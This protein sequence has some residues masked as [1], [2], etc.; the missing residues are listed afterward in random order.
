MTRSREKRR[1]LFLVAL[2]VIIAGLAVVSSTVSAMGPA[3]PK[4]EDSAGWQLSEG[5]RVYKFGILTDP[6]CDILTGH[7]IAIQITRIRLLN[8]PPGQDDRATIGIELRADDDDRYFSSPF[9]GLIIAGRSYTPPEIDQ[10][11]VFAKRDRPIFPEKLQPNQQRY[12]LPRG[13]KRFFRLRFP[14]SQS[15]LGQG[16]A[17]QVSGLQSEGETLQ[18]PTV[19][20]RWAS[21][22][23]AP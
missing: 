14:V 17:L 8:L 16:F 3:I 20:F 21:S 15:E 7:G 6:D 22:P 13:E 19:V 5:C 9:G 2:P 4:I 11:L 12:Q 1:A 10:A 18:V 23:R